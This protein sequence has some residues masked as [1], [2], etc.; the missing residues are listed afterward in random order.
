MKG[1]SQVSLFPGSEEPDEAR[2]DGDDYVP[3]RD[4][5]RLRT[6]L[7]RIFRFMR[8]GEWRTLHEIAQATG[9]PEASILAQLGHLRKERFGAYPVPKRHRGNP[10]LGLYEY[11][12]GAK[13]GGEPR[14]RYAPSA[15]FLRALDAADA[16]IPY[17]A[18]LPNCATT[19]GQYACTCHYV[20]VRKE[21]NT[22]RQETRGDR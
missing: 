16:L 20:E 3:E 4:D 6:Q 22:A 13:G 9:D 15:V 8:G 19:R 14:T 11:Q 21:W 7:D 2:F 10:S 12:L 17:L 5:P 1:S 18:H